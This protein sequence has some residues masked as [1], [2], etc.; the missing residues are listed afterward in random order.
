MRVKLSTLM[1]PA[2]FALAITAADARTV[3]WA[4]GAD[5]LTL[6][7]HAQNEGPTL[8]FG[9]QVYESLIARDNANKLI[10]GLAVS[11]RLAD[12]TT[13]EFHLRRGVKFHNGDDFTADDVVFSANR[14][15]AKGSNMQSRIP[16][17]AK[18][19]KVDDDTVDF[20]LSSPDPI[21]LAQWATWYIMD[22]KWAE[23]NNSSE[24]TPA[25]A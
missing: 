10:P 15:R 8:A 11:W 20:V 3:K 22:K 5:A 4:R 18:V 21:L 14:V 6:D 17:D 1:L 9:N 23:A 19:I 25:S 2:S 24:P 13:W 7:P 12:P 16:M